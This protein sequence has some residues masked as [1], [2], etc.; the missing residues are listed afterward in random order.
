M[1][2][3]PPGNGGSATGGRRPMPTHALKRFLFSAR[4]VSLGLLLV[5]VF[6]LYVAAS[7]ESFY[8]TTIPVQGTIT[9]P[10]AEIVSVSGLAGS[11]HFCR[12]SA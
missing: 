11:P 3:K 10:P 9:I 7:Q 4:W 5:T 8:L 6:A 1:C 2:P 12:R